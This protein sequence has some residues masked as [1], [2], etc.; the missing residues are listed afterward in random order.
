MV[1][2]ASDALVR[3]HNPVKLILLF[4]VSFLVY[5][6]MRDSSW[7]LAQMLLGIPAGLVS[8]L[9]LPG[10][11]AS[12]I[13]IPLKYQNLGTSVFLGLVIQMLLMQL[14]FLLSFFYFATPPIKIWVFGGN[15]FLLVLGATVLQLKNDYGCLKTPIRFNYG[16][17]FAILLAVSLILRFVLLSQV[18]GSISPDSALYA[19]FARQL[20]NGK[21]DSLVL[22]DSAVVELREGFDYMAHHAF[23]YVF[24]LSYLLIEPSTSGPIF[25]LVVIGVSVLFPIFEIGKDLFGERAALWIC[26]LVSVHPL[27]VF[28][29]VVGYGPEITSL[30][31]VLYAVLLLRDER[32]TILSLVMAGVLVGLVDVTWYANFYI[33]CFMLPV[34][35]ILQHFWSGKQNMRFVLLLPIVLIARLYYLNAPIFM[36]LWAAIFSLILLGRGTLDWEIQKPVSFYAALLIMTVVFRFPLQIVSES[37]PSGIRNLE[38]PSFLSAL[39]VTDWTGKMLQFMFFLTW[40]LGPVILIILIS[41]LIATRNKNTIG[42]SILGMVVAFGTF[43]VLGTIPESLKI[44]Y[45]YS[46]SRFFILAVLLFIFAAGEFFRRLSAT[47]QI[48]IPRIGQLRRGTVAVLTLSAI[49]IGFIPAYQ[50][51]PSGLSLIHMED[52][53]GW[54]GFQAIVEDLGDE[55][56]IFLANRVREFS[57]L[58][59]RKCVFLAFTDTALPNSNATSE[60]MSLTGEFSVD[61]LIIDMYTTTR[62][63]TL[64]FLLHQSMEIGDSVLLNGSII[65]ECVGE[66]TFGPVQSLTLVVQNEPNDAGRFSRIFKVDESYFSLNQSISVVDPGWE[67]S[68]NGEILNQSDNA[69]VII[70]AEA[71]QT[72]IHRDVSLNLLPETGFILFSIDEIDANV[73]SIEMLSDNNSLIGHGERIAEGLFICYHGEELIN[74]IRITVEGEAGESVVIESISFWT[75][76]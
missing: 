52:R 19:D 49:V 51:Y 16:W 63:Q 26:G 66:G 4:L 24:A 56:S 21:Y 39:L 12:R 3:F 55:D 58:T 34:A 41:T 2:I 71:S 64:I 33:I 36:L 44:I 11:V 76:D 42:L 15:L 20:V 73:T 35:A 17:Q 68:D 57:W 61:F 13:L 74:D 60:I 25:I 45:F 65:P 7:P 31:Y 43:V 37:I 22:N 59:G 53:Y 18:Q 70:G 72:I 32:S 10:I 14:R 1:S 29:S 40:H 48:H 67:A 30:L 38:A 5:F 28:H 50:M 8:I 75:D 6:T 46:D 54:D 47:H 23:T 27:F 62:W 9:L 69:Q